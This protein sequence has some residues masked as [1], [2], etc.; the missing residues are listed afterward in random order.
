MYKKGEKINHKLFGLGIILE[1]YDNKLKIKFDQQIKFISIKY[2]EIQNHNI[3]H[4]NYYKRNK[5]NHKIILDNEYDES[6]YFDEYDDEMKEAV[7]IDYGYLEDD[8]FGPEDGYYGEHEFIDS[9]FD[10]FTGEY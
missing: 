8:E 4:T 9:K 7:K 2:F 1:V 3:S 6:N 10:Y 5:Y